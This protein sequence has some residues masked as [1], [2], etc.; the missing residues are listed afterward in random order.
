MADRNSKDFSPTFSGNDLRHCALV[1]SES[2]SDQSLRFDAI[3]APNLADIIFGQLDKL[4]WG[5]FRASDMRPCSSRKN[6]HNGVLADTEMVRHSSL[7]PQAFKR[8][9]T[10][11]LGSRQFRISVLFAAKRLACALVPRTPLIFGAINPFEI[12]KS[13]I[14]A[15]AIEMV[16]LRQRIRVWQKSFCEKTVNSCSQ[17]RGISSPKLHSWVTVRAQIV[18]LVSNPAYA[19]EVGNFIERA[20]G[21][22]FPDFFNF[23]AMSMAETLR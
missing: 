23:H 13:K 22:W 16:D 1:D 9:N 2:F 18:R 14:R 12:F 20:S 19:T 17:V 3:K 6:D 21:N 5:R 10:R 7:T 8:T 4:E 11:D 15:V